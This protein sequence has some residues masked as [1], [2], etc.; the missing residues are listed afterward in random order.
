MRTAAPARTA[1]SLDMKAGPEPRQ[2]DR[3]LPLAEQL[4]WSIGIGAAVVWTLVMV[5]GTVGARAERERFA[6]LQAASA[7]VSDPDLRLWSPERVRAW[8]DAQKQESPAPLAMLR[9]PRLRLDVAVLDGTDEWTLNRAVGLIEETA[10]PGTDG[11]I[12][13]AGHRDG[14]FRGLKDIQAGDVLEIETLERVERYRV[15][16]AWIVQP[17][18]VSVLDPTPVPAVTLVTCYPFYFVGP[19]PQRFIVRAVR[20]GASTTKESP[21]E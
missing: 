6:A 13:I 8:Q 1:L 12:G 11:N 15:E 2:A 21:T 16:R 17:E 7:A 10:K 14:F 9:I 18:E 3:R 5:S 20:T 19:A 4:A